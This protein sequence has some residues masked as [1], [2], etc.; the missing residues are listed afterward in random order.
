ML[1][2][3]DDGGER[4]RQPRARPPRSRGRGRGK[5]SKAD[6]EVATPEAGSDT[7]SNKADEGGIAAAIDEAF[8]HNIALHDL[9]NL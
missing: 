8:Y 4:G 5:G 9:D 6:G 1:V 3:A 2:L 7:A